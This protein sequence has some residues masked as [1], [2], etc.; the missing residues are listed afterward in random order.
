MAYAPTDD[1][2]RWRLDIDLEAEKLLGL[3]VRVR[4]VRSGFDLLEVRSMGAV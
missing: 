4:G 3:R 1:G 2:G